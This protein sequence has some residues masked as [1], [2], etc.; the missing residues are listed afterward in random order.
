MQRRLFFKARLISREF[1][2]RKNYFHVQIGN[3]REFYQIHGIAEGTKKWNEMIVSSHCLTECRTETWM[4]HKFLFVPL[5]YNPQ[6][7]R[8][9]DCRNNRKQ[10]MCHKSMAS[11]ETGALQRFTSWRCFKKFFFDSLWN[12]FACII[13]HPQLSWLIFLSASMF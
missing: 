4:K 9:T 2:K 13:F 8:S 11:Y 3:R 1:S 12:L 10:K 5:F 6:A 7:K